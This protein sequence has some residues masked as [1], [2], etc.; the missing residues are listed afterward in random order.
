MGCSSGFFQK[1]RFEQQAAQFAFAVHVVT[2]RAVHQA[3]AFDLCAFFEHCACALDLQFFHQQH[4][5]AVLQHVAM[6]VQH[7]GHA[8]VCSTGAGVLAGGGALAWPFQP[9]IGADAEVAVGVGVFQ[10]ALRT[11]RQ[12][13]RHGNF[14]LWSGVWFANGQGWKWARP[15]PRCKAFSFTPLRFRPLRRCCATTKWGADN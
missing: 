4:R 2:V 8:I 13:R 15:A 11:G 10:S 3:D 14:S 9:A 5:V 12:G 1:L 6:G 7:R